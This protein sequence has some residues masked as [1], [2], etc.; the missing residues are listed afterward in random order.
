MDLLDKMNAAIIAALEE[1]KRVYGTAKLEQGQEFA[2]LLNDAVLIIGLEEDTLTTKFVIGAPY[3]I[4]MS[5]G[6]LDD[7]DDVP[8]ERT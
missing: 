8:R 6:W 3:R 2:T 4:D 1:R 5:I 7:L